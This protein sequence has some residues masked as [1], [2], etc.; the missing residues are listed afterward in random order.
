[1]K[2]WVAWGASW[3]SSLVALVLLVLGLGHE[4]A[5]DDFGL[6]GYGGVVFVVAASRSRPSAP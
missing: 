2:A 4:D 1:M 5:A 3:R 6:S